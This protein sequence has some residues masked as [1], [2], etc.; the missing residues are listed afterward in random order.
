MIAFLKRLLGIAEADLS[1]IL[2]N[3]HRTVKDLEAH[4]S[5]HTA[6]SKAKQLEA[7]AATAA[8]IAAA[9]AADKADRIA[10]NIK[11]LLDEHTPSL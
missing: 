8:A 11:K 6:V 9:T 3:F 4:V 2:T 10:S 1:N 7:D 5:F